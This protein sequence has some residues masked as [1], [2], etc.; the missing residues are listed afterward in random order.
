MSSF[1]QNPA[2]GGIPVSASPPIA[3]A[4]AVSRMCFFRPPIL[5]RSCVPTAWM[6]EPAA[7]NRRALKNACVNRWKRPSIAKPAPI[8][9]TM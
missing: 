5:K 3:N 1:D 6:T 4:A 9:N 2:N 7:R 8:A